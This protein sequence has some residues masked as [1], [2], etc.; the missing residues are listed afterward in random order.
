MTKTT[1]IL[2]LARLVPLASIRNGAHEENAARLITMFLLQIAGTML[3]LL[4]QS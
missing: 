2:G 4:Q 3:L 1:T